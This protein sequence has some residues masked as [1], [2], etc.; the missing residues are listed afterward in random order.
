MGKKI[1]ENVEG[2]QFLAINNFDLTKK[3]EECLAKNVWFLHFLVFDNYDF[4]RKL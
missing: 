2:L 3:I 1:R 4:P